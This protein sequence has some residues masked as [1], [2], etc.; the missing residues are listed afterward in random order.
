[1]MR[2][3]VTLSAANIDETYRP[4]IDL[5]FCWREGEGRGPVPLPCLVI[6]V[7]GDRCC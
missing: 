6:D 3:S 1:M 4:L 2:F 5:V 7:D